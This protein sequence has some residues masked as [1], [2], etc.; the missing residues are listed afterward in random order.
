MVKAFTDKYPNITVEEELDPWDGY[1]EKKTTQLA[2]DTLPDVFA[3][4]TGYI[5]EY[6][7][8]GRLLDLTPINDNP[9]VSG[10]VKDLPKTALANLTINGK[11]YG[12]PYAAGTIIL[13]YNKTMFD[14][15][16]V[17][18]P[19]PGWTYDDMLAAATKLTVDTNG[20]GEPDQWGFMADLTGIDTFEA[21]V[22][23]FGGRW[24]SDDATQSL[25]NSPET[26]EAMQFM[27]DLAYKY[28]V[29]A[30][31]QDLEGVEDPFASQLVAMHL[32]LVAVMGT[33]SE[34]TDFQWDIAA[35]P[36]GFKGQAAAGAIR[37]NPN[38]VVSS[39]TAHPE[40]SALLAAWLS[41]AEA[42]SILGKAKGRFP[43]H[44][45]GQAEWLSAPPENFNIIME[46]MA[47]DVANEPLCVNHAAEIE[48]AW[49]RVLEGEIL[50]N[51]KPVS[52][53]APVMAEEIQALL[54]AK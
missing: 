38:Y 19:K 48:E 28:K 40:E 9:V 42:Q 5:C 37:G 16:G 1:W 32:S 49:D 24:L 53:I 14:A 27:Q 12:F 7:A 36:L 20:D 54:D 4:S 17:E 43:A 44:P 21:V 41:S 29:S 30:R 11:Q 3:M 39:K 23:S 22:H 33:L 51:A 50:T 45:A 26:V 8:A 18:Y 2:S 47:N 6:V 31:P 15:A 34:V 13:Y 46:L 52:E 10:W 25:A 35:P